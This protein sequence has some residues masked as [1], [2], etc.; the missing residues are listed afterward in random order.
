MKSNNLILFWPHFNLSHDLLINFFIMTSTYTEMFSRPLTNWQTT[1]NLCINLCFSY[2]NVCST[3]ALSSTFTCRFTTHASLVLPIKSHPICCLNWTLNP[4]PGLIT[5]RFQFC[6]IL[7]ILDTFISP[8]RLLSSAISFQAARLFLP[9]DNGPL[10]RIKP[11][12]KIFF[13]PL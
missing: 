7:E 11:F 3:K 10:I 9:G 12:F 5:G 1:I 2:N 6:C 4:S 8:K 13:A